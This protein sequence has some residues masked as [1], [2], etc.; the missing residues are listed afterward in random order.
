[1]HGFG[2]LMTSHS[3]PP[4]FLD[5]SHY[6][7]VLCYT[8]NTL[9]ILSSVF[10]KDL[11]TNGGNDISCVCIDFYNHTPRRNMHMHLYTHDEWNIVMD[12]E[13]EKYKSNTQYPSP[14]YMRCPL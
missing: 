5:V 4:I 2:N 10:F 7:F 14:L 12:K 13:K 8:A 9:L 11:N 3:F 6:I 1:M